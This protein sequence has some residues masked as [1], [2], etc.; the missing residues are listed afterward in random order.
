MMK[1]N[2]INL[3]GVHAYR[4]QTQQTKSPAS[5]KAFKDTLEISK[6]AQTAQQIQTTPTYETARAEKLASLKERVES[7]TYAVDAK[8]VATDMLKYYRL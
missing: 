1:I 3:N 5:A 2:H 7:G 4:Q 8:K 6:A